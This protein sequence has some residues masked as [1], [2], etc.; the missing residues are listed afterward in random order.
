MAI[1]G[2]EPHESAAILLRYKLK[3]KLGEGQIQNLS[4]EMT[5]DNESEGNSD[6]ALHY[7][8]FNINQLLYKAFSGIFP[9][10]KATKVAFELNFKEDPKMQRVWFGSYTTMDPIYTP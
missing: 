2:L 5:D 3:E 6:I 9:K 7:A 4:H 8:L 1:S 10:A